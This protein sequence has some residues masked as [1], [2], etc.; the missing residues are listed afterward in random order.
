MAVNGGDWNNSGTADPT[1]LTGGIPIGFGGPYVPFMSGYNGAQYGI[2]NNGTTALYVDNG[3]LTTGGSAGQNPNQCAWANI[4]PTQSFTCTGLQVNVQPTATGNIT[5]GLYNTSGGAPTTLI[6]KSSLTAIG[7]GGVT[8]FAITPTAVTAG[9]TY[10]IGYL[11]TVSGTSLLYQ[12][13]LPNSS[14]FN[15]YYQSGLS[16]NLPSTASPTGQFGYGLWVGM[17]GGPTGFQYPLTGASAW[18]SSLTWTSTGSAQFSLNQ[19]NLAAQMATGSGNVFGNVSQSTS[20]PGL[21]YLEVITDRITASAAAIGIANTSAAFTT[22]LPNSGAPTA[23][24]RQDGNMYAVGGGTAVATGLSW[25]SNV[26]ISIAFYIPEAN[27]ASS[28]FFAA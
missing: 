14:G 13:G 20:V 3:L 8:T 12:A 23:F 19:G 1:T 4:T 25:N 27:A 10:A 5:V 6:Q 2:I 21:W 9:V 22:G 28:G 16:G 26:P 15:C 18:S 17:A 24:L 11:P 7:S